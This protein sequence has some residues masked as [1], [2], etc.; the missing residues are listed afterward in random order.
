MFILDIVCEKINAVCSFLDDFE[1][2][3]N[4]ERLQLWKRE[5]DILYARANEEAQATL[6][7]FDRQLKDEDRLFK[8]RQ[9]QQQRLNDQ[10]QRLNDQQQYK[11]KI[12]NLDQTI[13]RQFEDFS[14]YGIIK[15]TQS[16]KGGV[17]PKGLESI[18]LDVEPPEDLEQFFGDVEE[19][20]DHS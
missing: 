13:G 12:Q 10:Q 8:E 17:Q 14:V 20:E 18:T 19:T 2:A 11:Q 1:K 15:K 4:Q 7:K 3:V 16:K 5:Q 9:L 6:L